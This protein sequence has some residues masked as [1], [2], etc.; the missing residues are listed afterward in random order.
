[1]RLALPVAL[2]ASSLT[3]CWNFASTGA[4]STTS[5][6]E[7]SAGSPDS[8]RTAWVGNTMAPTSFRFRPVITT[9]WI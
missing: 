2:L 3:I 5:C 1:M 8:A 4:L 6:I 9:S 7:A